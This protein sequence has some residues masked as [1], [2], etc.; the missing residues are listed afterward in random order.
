MVAG[1]GADV[2]DALAPAQLQQLAHAGDDERLGDRRPSPIGSG[3]APT[4]RRPATGGRSARA[5][6][7][8]SR[9]DALVGYV[10][11][12]PE[13]ALGVHATV[14]PA[15]RTSPSARSESPG[16]PRPR[17]RRRGRRSPGSRRA[18]HPGRCSDA[19]VRREPGD[20]DRG[21]PR[22][23]AGSLE[24]GAL[25]PAVAVGRPSGPC[26]R[27]RRPWSGRAPGAVGAERAGD[28]V[29]RPGGGE[30]AVVGRMPVAGRDH[31][32][33]VARPESSLIRGAISSPCGTARAPPG[34]KS[35]WKSTMTRAR[36]M[37][38]PGRIR[39]G[40]PRRP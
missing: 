2:E 18:G 4:P 20:G 36:G 35:F 14:P 27:S 19:I 13:Q 34:V 30:R 1:A 32:V 33:V 9:E 40:P 3:M 39:R 15:A 11:R 24:V 8:H 26:R 38:P 23:R 25:E 21:R 37:S 7:S 17:A 31:D 12:I 16:P 28:A 6:R 5:A 22:A 10:P 29:H